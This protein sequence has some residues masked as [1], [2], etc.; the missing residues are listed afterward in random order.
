MNRFENIKGFMPKI[1][2]TE[3]HSHKSGTCFGYYHLKLYRK[4]KIGISNGDLKDA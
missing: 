1:I 3:G 2:A 4:V